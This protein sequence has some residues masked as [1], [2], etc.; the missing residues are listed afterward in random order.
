MYAAAKAS[1]I[2][3]QG[4]EIAASARVE[5]ERSNWATT[6]VRASV[7]DFNVALDGMGVAEVDSPPGDDQ[8]R[9]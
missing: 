7:H 5:W 4:T 3:V 9:N 2:I 6:W 8:A 1:S